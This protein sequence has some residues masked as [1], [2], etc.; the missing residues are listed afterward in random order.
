MHFEGSYHKQTM[1]TGSDEVFKYPDS[2]ITWFLH[3]L[4]NYTVSH[5]YNYHVSTNNKIKRRFTE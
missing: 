4:K 3:E 2:I 5:M 1:N